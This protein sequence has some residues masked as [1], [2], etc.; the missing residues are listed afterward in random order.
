ME[1]IMSRTYRRRK[2]SAK[3][4][5]FGSLAEY[6]TERVGTR[7]WFGASYTVP[8]DPNTQEYKIKRSEYYRDKPHNFK[9]PGP[10]W[11]RNLFST[12]PL[13]GKAKKELHKFVRSV[14]KV[15]TAKG[16][17][18]YFLQVMNECYEPVIDSKGKL[19]YWT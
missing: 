18:C 10:S 7:F 8:L 12:R 1:V 3:Y 15:Y 11:F 19:P 5:A 6:T 17:E 2:G 13:R 14:P 16:K 4:R 9:E